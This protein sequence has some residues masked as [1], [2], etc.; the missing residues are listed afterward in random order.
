MELYIISVL[1]V[2]LMFSF[3]ILGVLMSRKNLVLIFMS[4]ELMLMS[5]VMGFGFL[6]LFSED[7]FYQ[8]MI[9]VLLV[10]GGVEA[11]IGLAVL[12][13][14]YRLSGDLNLETITLCKG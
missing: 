13:V 6:S 10:L 5:V 7:V 8:A 14:Y 9:L 12:V 11:A 2:V 3:G 1:G 4:I